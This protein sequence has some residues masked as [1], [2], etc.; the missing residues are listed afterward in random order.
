[1][2]LVLRHNGLLRDVLE[3]GMM[4]KRTRGR[5]RIELIDD[6]WYMSWWL[7]T[8]LFIQLITYLKS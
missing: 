6:T 1:M 5:R 2:G 4:R 7:F 3:G 8:Y